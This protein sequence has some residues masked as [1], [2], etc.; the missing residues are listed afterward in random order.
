VHNIIATSLEAAGLLKSGKK[1][2]GRSPGAVPF[3][4][5]VPGIIATALQA[6]GVLDSSGQ[7]GRAAADN[8]RGGLVGSGWE[9]D[10]W[11]FLHDDPRAFRGG[12]ILHCRAVSGDAQGTGRR[13]WSVSRQMSLGPRPELSYVRRISLSAAVNPY[14]SASFRVLVED[15]VVDEVSA[16]GMEYAETEWTRRAGIDLSRFADRT[17]TVTLEATAASNVPSAVVAEV[18]LDEIA[19]DNA[20]EVEQV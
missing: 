20:T 15:A 13:A 5:D 10:G 3:G 14:T 9:G 17:V 7:G 12:P 19:V 8:G 6:A 1:E 16:I 2:A 4:I 11:E 18:W